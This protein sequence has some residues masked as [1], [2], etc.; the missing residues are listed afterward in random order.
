MNREETHSNRGEKNAGRGE[1]GLGWYHARC[2]LREVQ[3]TDG[4]VERGE[5]TIPP[6]QVWSLGIAC[7]G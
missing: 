2:L 7:R 6:L 1:R 5:N 4:H 3:S